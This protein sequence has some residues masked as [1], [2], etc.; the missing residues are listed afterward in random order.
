[1]SPACSPGVAPD[2][3][4]RWSPD[5][6]R[7]PVTPSLHPPF[8][9]APRVLIAGG[10]I[11]ALE[12]ALTIREVVQAE[13]VVIEL[14]SPAPDFTYPPLAVLEPFGG[15][16]PW[17]V[18]L[19]RFARDVDAIWRQDRVTRV[20]ADGHVVGTAGRQQIAYTT[21]LLATGARQRPWLEGAL[22]FGGD[23]GATLRDALEAC[24]EG[25]VAGLV[26]VI[27]HG[28]GRPLPV[29]ELALLSAGWLHERGCTDV[30][31]TVVTSE[32]EPLN[33]FGTRA[34]AT[35]RSRLAEKG[36][37]LRTAAAV[38][39]VGVGGPVLT[40]G[41]RISADWT[42]T[43]PLLSGPSIA[44]VPEND[45][46]FVTVDRL[47]RVRGLDDVFAAGDITNFPH[48]HGSLATQQADAAAD[49]ILARLGLPIEPRPFHPV[50]Q[51]VLYDD[52][53]PAYLRADL[54]RRA[55]QSPRSYSFWWPPSKV[56]G[57]RLSP[58]LH[59]HAGAPRSP[60]VR[61]T[62]D[63]PARSERA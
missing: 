12:A 37:A 61:P 62:G 6:I 58:Y 23:S 53:A 7:D 57:R 60:E 2:L 46:G 52:S 16:A 5:G 43:L 39:R 51:G 31:L 33:A 50:L 35:V 63:G 59:V 25:G 15:G 42:I 36:I 30:P 8:D 28:G 54:D 22:T 24:T 11:A 14:V 49:A 13:E 40:S 41:E 4:A 1:M 17:R 45:D 34:S 26:F 27:P 32:A 10:G 19:E 29:Y 47:G 20:D 55:E 18:P 3:G 9:E 56:A 44:G 38:S 48:K 21:L